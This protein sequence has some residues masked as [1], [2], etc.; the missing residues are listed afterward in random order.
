MLSGSGASTRC[1]VTYTPSDFGTKGS[2]TITADYSGDLPSQGH[3][4]HVAS[5]GSGAVSVEQRSARTTVGCS[6]NPVAVERPTTC[7][8]TITDTSAGTA[9]TPTVVPGSA[10]ADV[11]LKRARNLRAHGATRG[12]DG[13][14]RTGA[15]D[16]EQ[17]LERRD[18][19]PAPAHMH[20]ATP[21][22]RSAATPERVGLAEPSAATPAAE[23]SAEPEP[24][25]SSV[26]EVILP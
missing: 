1:S 8:A 4:A 19:P 21:E 3:G 25:R 20:R 26:S 24:S 7:V 17:E 23:R 18:V 2:Q 11:G 22:P 14:C 5:S 6:P 9:T 13:E 15:A 12:R 10:G 16:V